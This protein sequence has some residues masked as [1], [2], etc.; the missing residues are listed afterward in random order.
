MT[1]DALNASKMNRQLTDGVS[2]FHFDFHKNIPCPKLSCQESYYASKLTTY[3]FGIHSGETAK[4]TTYVWPESIAPKNPDSLMS[5]LYL[6]L[7]E[8]EEKNRSWNIFWADNTRSQN[9]NYSV[10]MFFDHLVSSGFR[11]RIDYKFLIP[12][13]SYAAVDRDAGQAEH[14]LRA[15]HTIETPHD[16]V[17]LI[18]N[19]TLKSHIKW[20][21]M[22]QY[23]FRWYSE[24]LRTK[25]TESRKDVNGK[26]F[27]F[28]E[29]SYFNF[30]VGERVSP[31]D[32]I[33]KTY[34]HNGTVWM[35]KTQNPEE[36]PI[37][38]D[39]RRKGGRKDLNTDD[40]KPLS[41][42]GNI[43][44]TRKKREDLAK[45]RKFLSPNGK[46]YYSNVIQSMQ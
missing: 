6:H 42:S 11:K 22:E 35:R 23:Q 29:I 16:F 28:S 39:L 44:L 26:A 34:S 41:D 30:G 36:E 45:L 17:G 31:D 5:C 2:V 10:V 4:G 40:L 18:N 21:E 33:V 12:G 25:Y 32:G 37:V 38:M 1:K 24:W 27:L 20:I 3:A 14:V 7:T 8:T 15:E 9:K 13:H 43:E 19:S 46:K